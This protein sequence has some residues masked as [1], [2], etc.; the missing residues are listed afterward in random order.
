MKNADLASNPYVQVKEK[1]IPKRHKPVKKPTQ[2]LNID[3][4]VSIENVKGE[5]KIIG[6]RRD[7]LECVQ[8]ESNPRYI[9]KC[10]AYP[11]SVTLIRIGPVSIKQREEEAERES[12]RGFKI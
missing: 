8:L 12:L 1:H 9:S 2:K 4:I 11:D 6:W 10:F 7:E 5:F 3:D